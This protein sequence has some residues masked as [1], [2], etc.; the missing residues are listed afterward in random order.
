MITPRSLTMISKKMNF[1]LCDRLNRNNR[2]TKRKNGRYTYHA[3]SN[4]N[5]D[6]WLIL[7]KEEYNRPV[8]DSKAYVADVRRVYRL[9]CEEDIKSEVV[10]RKILSQISL[11]DVKD[12]ISRACRIREGKLDGD[13]M[14]IGSS[15]CYPNPDFSIHNFL[16]TVLRDCNELQ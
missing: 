9:G 1:Q 4:V 8:S 3:Y 6:L 5:F 7:H 15:Y 16:M 10:I 12:A 14:I 2:P 13:R 11:N